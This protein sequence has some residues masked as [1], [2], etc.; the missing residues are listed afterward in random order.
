MFQILVVCTANICRSPVAEVLLANLLK[1]KA[2]RVESAGTSA[3]NNYNAD[4]TMTELMAMRGFSSLNFHRSKMLLASQV[5]K[6]DLILCM[7]NS[8]I[9]AV[10]RLQIGGRG[11]IM[12]LGH[13]AG[14]EQVQ[15]PIGQDRLVYE[16]SVEQMTILTGQ[17]ADKITQLGI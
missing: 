16:Q 5:S 10:E 2:I 6:Y 1:G 11:K 14:E 12:L 8:H 7:E 3:Q 15:D 9:Q 4:A 17:W 13:W